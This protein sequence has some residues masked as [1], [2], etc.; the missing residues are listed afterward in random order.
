MEP[1]FRFVALR[2]EVEPMHVGVMSAAKPNGVP[3]LV[4]AFQLDEVVKAFQLGF[5]VDFQKF[6]D[7][8]RPVGSHDP[9][10]EVQ[11]IV[12]VLRIVWGG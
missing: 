6:N 12:V 3:C 9:H 7:E 10:R 2:H 8:S 5:D 11:V 1:Q 4:A